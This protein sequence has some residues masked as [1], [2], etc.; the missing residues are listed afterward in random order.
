M[1][2]KAVV[3]KGFFTVLMAEDDPDDRFITEAAFLEIGNAGE[4]RF[5]EDGEELMDY[6]CRLGKYADPILS[7]RPRLILLD[8]NMPKKDGRQA[9][10]EIKVNPD[11]KSIPVA[12]WTT[13]KEREDKVL[14]HELGSD[15]FVTKPVNYGDL[16]S[17]LRKVITTYCL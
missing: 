7:P 1:N 5:V 4:M 13:S 6:L 10:K 9:L 11:L 17:S 8:L 12:I 14:C 3:K 15:V 2:E 16:V